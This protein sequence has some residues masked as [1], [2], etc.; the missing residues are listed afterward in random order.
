VTPGSVFRNHHQTIE[1][2]H[3]GYYLVES[4]RRFVEAQGQ[5]SPKQRAV[6]ASAAARHKASGKRPSER[7]ARAALQDAQNSR[8]FSEHYDADA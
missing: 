1:D 7:I 5:I 6:L 3:F 2:G 8:V 4:G